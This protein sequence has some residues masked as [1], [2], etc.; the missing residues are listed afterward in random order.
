M[1]ETSW[2]QDCKIALVF[3][4]SSPRIQMLTLV[5]KFMLT[6]IET[7]TFSLLPVVAFNITK[8]KK[9]GFST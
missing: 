7:L 8:G 9:M 3:E 5:I 6:T 4:F 1:Q 2:D